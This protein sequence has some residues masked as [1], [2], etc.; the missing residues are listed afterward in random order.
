VVCTIGVAD[1]PAGVASATCSF[2]IF[3]F[4]P[5]ASFVLQQQS[6]TST[7]PATGTRNSGTF[8]CTVTFPR[9]AAGGA[10][11][12]SVSLTDL[13]GNSAAYPQAATENVDC[14][15]VGDVETTCR[16]G[17]NKQSLTWDVVAG[18]TRYNVYRGPFTNLVDVNLD[19][20]PD[21]GYGTCQNS[22]DAVLTD[23][24][25]LDADIPSAAQKGFFYLVSY[26]TGGL[27]KGL[28]WNSFGTPRTVAPCP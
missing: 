27:E 16:F 21:G 24:S 25:F 11:S 19:H 20:V 14:A 1:S 8:Q 6:C 7:T 28:G 5:P 9:Y 26:T 15:T 4:V 13:A 12:S 2:N 23:T 17:A 18:V 3:V 22:R 10:W